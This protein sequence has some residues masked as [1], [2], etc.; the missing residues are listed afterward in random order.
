MNMETMLLI[1]NKF[2]SEDIDYNL[3]RSSRRGEY[4]I[5]T[6]LWNVQMREGLTVMRGVRAGVE[7]WLAGIASKVTEER[8][9]C[10]SLICRTYYIENC[11]VKI[12]LDDEF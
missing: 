3:N 6:D 1:V 8:D 5:Q 10:D 2:E 4:L 12:D 11:V 7:K 9:A